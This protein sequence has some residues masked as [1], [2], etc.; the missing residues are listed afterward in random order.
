MTAA[1]DAP[2][3]RGWALTA[4]ADV[5]EAAGNPEAQDA[6]LRQALELYRSKGDVV[7]VGQLESRLKAEA[8]A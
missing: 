5:Q 3:L 2:L 8:G 7:T 1:S 4:L 6:A